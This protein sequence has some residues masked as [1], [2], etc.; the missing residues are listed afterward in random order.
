MPGPPPAGVSSTLRWRSVAESLM[1]R[2]SS[3]H[4]PD[5][6]AL[7]A[8]LTPSGPGN[9]S[10]NSVRTVA[11]QVIP[12]THHVSVGDVV[13]V[14]FLRQFDH[15]AAAGEIDRRHHRIG[16]RQQHGRALRRRDLDDVAGAEIMDRDDAA[17]RLVR[18]IDRGKP[19]QIGVVI[20][21]LVG[22][23]QFF[24]R[25]IEL[26]AVEPFG[27]LAGGDA[28]Q[29]RHQMVFGL[30]DCVTSNWRAPSLVISGP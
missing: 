27:V 16:E 13:A 21:V 26:D 19:D 5:A 14:D 4:R 12:E 23:G 1:S 2:A 29:R 28:L 11:R 25:D 22:R 18:G 3:A 7:P 10:G 24:A 17:E 6:S 8:R 30:A 20:F 15:H 9:I